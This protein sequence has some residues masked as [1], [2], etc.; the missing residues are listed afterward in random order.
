MPIYFVM[1]HL[2]FLKGSPVTQQEDP[3]QHK[4]HTHI[5]PYPRHDM[6]NTWSIYFTYIFAGSSQLVGG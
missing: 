1:F 4:N 2:G 5:Q 6:L 3:G